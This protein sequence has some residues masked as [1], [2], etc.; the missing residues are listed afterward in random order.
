[1]AHDPQVDAPVLHA[2]DL[3][4]LQPGDAADLLPRAQLEGH[5]L[6]D[7]RFDVLDVESA[8]LVECRVEGLVAG[9]VIARSAAIVECVLERMDVPAFRAVRGRWRDV[10][11][12]GSRLGV[13]EAYDAAWS[14]VHLVGCRL[15]Y[16]NLRGS[17]LEDVAFTDC[18]VDEL[19]LGQATVE[20]LALPGT[21]CTSLDLQGATL[22]HADL[23]GAEVRSLTGIGSMAGAVVS[24]AQLMELAHLLAEDRG[25]LV[26]D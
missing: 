23:R 9:E 4:D 17:R 13:V 22:E 25:I 11:L 2:V 12:A 3:S 15:G 5:E 14:A 21:R 26:V 24:R 8:S 7:L 6:T 19:D 10:E 16:V 18:V 20:R 1:M